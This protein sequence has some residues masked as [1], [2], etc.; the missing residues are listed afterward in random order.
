[1][2][3]ASWYLLVASL[4]VSHRATA[5]TGPPAAEGSPPAVRTFGDAFHAYHL[6]LALVSAAPLRFADTPDMALDPT[7]VFVLGGRVGFG[8]G[9][10]RADNHRVGLA[11][12]YETVAH[13][14]ERS[15]AL[16]TPQLTYETGDPLVLGVGLGYAIA[17]GTTGFADN[18]EGLA[19]SGTLG[20]S[21]IDRDRPG[22]RVGALLGINAQLITTGDA[23]YASAYLGGDLSFRFHF[24]AQGGAR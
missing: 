14:A 23:D 13:S 19:I 9:D 12:G 18:Y 11:V 8:F 16:I 20:W 7:T 1:M 10:P 22:A 5:D 4:S 24:G 15:L 17:R 3:P 6:D 2:R 21:F